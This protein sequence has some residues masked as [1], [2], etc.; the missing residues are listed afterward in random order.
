VK[1]ISSLCKG[2]WGGILPEYPFLRFR[3][4]DLEPF[5]RYFCLPATNTLRI[6]LEKSVPQVQRADLRSCRDIE[7]EPEHVVYIRAVGIKER[8]N[9]RIGNEVIK[10]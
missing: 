9:V 1:P 7:D 5:T 8:N 4:L 3:D 10:L 2:R 6:G